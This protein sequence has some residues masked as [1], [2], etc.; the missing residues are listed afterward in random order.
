[1][2][3][4][5]IKDGEVYAAA[6][7]APDVMAALDDPGTGAPLD[8]GDHS[9]RKDEY[10]RLMAVAAAMPDAGVDLSSPTSEPDETA[11]EPAM[12][13]D[14]F[15]APPLDADL[16]DM[17]PSVRVSLMWPL[18]VGGVRLDEVS[19]WPPLHDD[20]EAVVLGTMSRADMITNMAK[21]PRGLL[22]RMRFPDSDRVVAIALA[23][24]PDMEGIRL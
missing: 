18:N 22:G 10:R 24:A 1:M 6:D 2:V 12:A 9:H 14:D 13:D 19:L 3:G 17:P 8:G 20:V 11:P 23:L 4:T 16:V 15:Y 5:V 7:L 21:L